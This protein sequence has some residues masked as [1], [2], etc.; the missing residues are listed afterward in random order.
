MGCGLQKS[1]GTPGKREWPVAMMIPT[2]DIDIEED[3]DESD[4]SDD[5][6]L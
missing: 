1:L 2:H 4:E 5:E 3:E 6:D